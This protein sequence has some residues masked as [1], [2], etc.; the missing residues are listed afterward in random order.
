MENDFQN[1][2]VLHEPPELTEE[3]RETLEKQN[4]RMVSEFQANKLESQACKNWNLFY[5][6]N[7]TR[8]FKDR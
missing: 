5:K 8:F 3:M 1:N 4:S 7:E 2:L 6:R